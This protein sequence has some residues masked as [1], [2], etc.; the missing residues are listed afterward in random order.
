MTMEVNE[1]EMFVSAVVS[2]KFIDETVSTAAQQHNFKILG[3]LWVTVNTKG[4]EMA[5]F[6]WEMSRHN[7]NND[8][9]ASCV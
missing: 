2:Q 8:A 4:N 6:V 9:E 3:L 5:L 1:K 7:I